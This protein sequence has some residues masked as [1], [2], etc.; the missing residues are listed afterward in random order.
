MSRYK[1]YGGQ[2]T[3][4]VTLSFK[5]STGAVGLQIL[6]E[7]VKI[8]G[9]KAKTMTSL[10]ILPALLAKVLLFKGLAG[11]VLRA[12]FHSFLFLSRI[13]IL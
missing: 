7:V 4:H 13:I 5:R 11:F 1:F 10:L 3:S 9:L 2:V 12:Q 8:P 6:P